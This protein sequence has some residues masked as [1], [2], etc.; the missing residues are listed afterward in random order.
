MKV[1][2]KKSALALIV[3]S[4]LLFSLAACEDDTPEV[5]VYR[6]EERHV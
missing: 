6:S 2:T 4:T 1:F 5:K 3:V